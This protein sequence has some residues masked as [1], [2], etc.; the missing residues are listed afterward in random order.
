MARARAHRRCGRHLAGG[1]RSDPHRRNPPFV[2]DDEAAV[3][4]FARELVD[5]HAVSD[6]TYRAV[7]DRLGKTGIVELVGILGYYGLISMT[8]VAFQVPVPAGISR[9]LHNQL[10]TR[11]GIVCRMTRRPR[12]RC[13]PQSR[14]PRR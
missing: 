8:I 13:I 5:G 4:A 11:R 2:E 7:E 3:Y 10:T 1:R 12:R 9:S 14:Y 6:S